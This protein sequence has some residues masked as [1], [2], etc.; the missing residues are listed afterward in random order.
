ML[1]EHRLLPLKLITHC[2]HLDV[3]ALTS[4]A[5]AE[6]DTGSLTTVVLGL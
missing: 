4:P 5:D 1:D 6:A 3:Q 2:L